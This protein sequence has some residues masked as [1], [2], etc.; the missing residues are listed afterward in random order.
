MS[1]NTDY[2]AVC[3]DKDVGQSDDPMMN[4]HDL[5]ISVTTD[6]DKVKSFLLDGR[7]CMKV[8]LTTYQS[9]SVIISAC[10][11]IDQSFDLGIFDEAHK[12]TGDK[13][14]KFALLID[15]KKLEI[16]NKIF[17]TATERQF[18]GNTTNLMSMDDDSIYGLVIDQLSFKNALDQ[19][20]PIL[21]DYKVITIAVTRSDIDQLISENQLTRANGQQH[22]FIDDGA[23]I[24]SLIALRKLSVDK[25]IKHAISFHKSIKRAN[26]FTAL[27]NLLNDTSDT[28]TI[29]KAFH[30]SGAM[31]TSSR[32]I[33]INK[34][35]KSQPSV[36]SNARC[37]TEGVDIPLVDAVLFSDPKQSVIDIV[38][39]AGRAMRTHP[40]KSLGYIIIPVIIDD[41]I[42]DKV[43]EAFKQLVNVV[44]ALG[45]SDNRIID[46]AK[47]LI[48]SK[49]VSSNNILQF[50]TFSPQAEIQFSVLEKEIKLKIWDRLSF[51]KSTIGESKFTKWMQNESELSKASMEKYTRVVRKISN[52]LVRRNL[53]YSSL[54]EI[55][56]K[57]DLER[58]KEKYFSFDE[59]KDLDTRGNR[60]YSAGFNQLIKYQNF[61]K[62][63]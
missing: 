15:D 34:F 46:E 39:A 10:D 54:D 58:L 14:K 31:N 61:L 26:E 25:G 6:P 19:E 7:P 24:A 9:G 13:S 44:A 49:A 43:N 8:V 30:V 45:I 37:L 21:C 59:Y 42:S 17:M 22:T 35:I 28:Q 55:T 52:D 36:I 32:N 62:N 33:E 3:S 47:H 60:M 4:T 48:G 53:S 12:T 56:E 16:K 27:N 57:A 2:I 29:L 38:Q 50:E 18:S 1:D 63:D 51:A 23:T 41:H 40:E 11:K 20:P 5:G